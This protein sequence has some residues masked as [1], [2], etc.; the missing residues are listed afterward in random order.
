MITP[1]K[2]PKLAD[3][4][5]RGFVR[6]FPEM[7]H[8]NGT[9][10]R[11]VF[12]L[13]RLAQ[14]EGKTPE[15]KMIEW[16]LLARDVCDALAAGCSYDPIARRC[17]LKVDLGTMDQAGFQRTVEAVRRGALDTLTMGAGHD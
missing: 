13:V 9:L 14:R 4:T 2:D 10:L 1:P 6:D 8:G 15:T 17:A 3:E 16:Q 5:Y 12:E 11:A 7:Y